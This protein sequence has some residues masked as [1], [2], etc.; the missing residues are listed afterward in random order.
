MLQ[1]LDDNRIVFDALTRE[2]M[3]KIL[4][5]QLG[6]VRGMLAQRDLTLRISDAAKTVICDVGYDP[7]F[8]ARPLKRTIT[9]H[10][11]NPMSSAIIEGGY[12][13]GDTVEVDVEGDNLVFS[14]IPAPKDED[15]DEGAPKQLV[16]G[17]PP[18]A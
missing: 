2:D 17:P 12:G 16:D 9:S 15:E 5:I 18:P 1:L 11:L 13:V 3:D 10:L 8:G 4:E 14:R 6:R 7:A